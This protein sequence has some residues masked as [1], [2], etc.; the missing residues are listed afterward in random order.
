[1]AVGRG[2]RVGHDHQPIGATRTSRGGCRA[3]RWRG[4][5]F[6]SPYLW[7]PGMGGPSWWSSNEVFR[8]IETL[9]GDPWPV[10]RDLATWR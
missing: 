7:R 5:L 8:H 3:R 6:C 2:R 4:I 9:D 1:M 10:I